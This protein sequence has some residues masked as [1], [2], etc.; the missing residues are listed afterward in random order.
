MQRHVVV[1]QS[2]SSCNMCHMVLWS[3]S[4]S[5]RHIWC[6]AAFGVV[7]TVIMPHLMLQLLSSC[8]A[9]SHVHC[10]CAVFVLQFLSSRHV[11]CCGHCHHATFSVAV[12][13]VT[14]H[15]VL[16]SRWVSSSRVVSQSRLLRGRSGCCCAVVVL[17]GVAVMAVVPCGVVEL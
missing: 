17:H 9:W 16:W 4:Q 11:W 8:S 5:S 7:G 12:A 1:S 14:P 10:H 6:R 13:V 3:W 15:V 2:W